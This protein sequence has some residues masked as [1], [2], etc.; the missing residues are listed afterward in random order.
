MPKAISNNFAKHY[1]NSPKWQNF[2]KSSHTDSG[3]ECLIPFYLNKSHR[4]KSDVE[5]SMQIERMKFQK[6]KRLK[7]LAGFFPAA[8]APNSCLI[9][10]MVKKLLPCYIDFLPLLAESVIKLL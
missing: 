10:S 7:K 2:A 1:K 8:N 5:K 6:F 9:A 3:P 4:S